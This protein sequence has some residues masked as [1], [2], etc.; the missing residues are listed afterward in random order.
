MNK[1]NYQG[2]GSNLKDVRYA[3]APLGPILLILSIFTPLKSFLKKEECSVGLNG[4]HH[5]GTLRVFFGCLVLYQGES[6]LKKSLINFQKKSFF[7][8][9]KIEN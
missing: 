9:T 4:F 1:T 2:S 6:L 7:D 5:N 3:L 8:K